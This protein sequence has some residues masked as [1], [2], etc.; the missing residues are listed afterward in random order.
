MVMIVHTLYFMP[1]R[2]LY[3]A[4]R[5]ISPSALCG[6]MKSHEMAVHAYEVA[7]D[8]IRTQMLYLPMCTLQY[9][10]HCLCIEIYLKV[11]DYCCQ[12]HFSVFFS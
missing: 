12:L 8:S 1:N 9:I 6:H 7:I 3:V 5:S 4:I 2:T 10:I 11:H